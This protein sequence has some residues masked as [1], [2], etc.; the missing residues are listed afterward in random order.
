MIKIKF[1]DHSEENIV[2][3]KECPSNTSWDSLFV[4]GLNDKFIIFNNL[5]VDRGKTPR[6]NFFLIRRGNSIYYKQVLNTSSDRRRGS[7][8]VTQLWSTVVVCLVSY[9]L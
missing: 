9:L 6:F 1:R 5:R 4:G 2:P 7:L 8:S 3:F